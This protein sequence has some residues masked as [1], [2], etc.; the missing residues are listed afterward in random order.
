MQ[1]PGVE[2]PGVQVSGAQG[3]GVQGPR[4]AGFRCAGSRCAGCTC[5]MVF[6]FPGVQ[7]VSGSQ[8]GCVFFFSQPGRVSTGNSSLRKHSEH[9]EA[10]RPQDARAEVTIIHPA[11]KPLALG[12]GGDVFPMCSSFR[13]VAEQLPCPAPGKDVCVL[14][15]ELWHFSRSRPHLAAILISVAH[16]CSCEQ[17]KKVIFLYLK[18]RTHI[19]FP[20]D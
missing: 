1:V 9:R 10:T 6:R 5:A 20:V 18:Y 12:L 16:S 15:A 17:L 13:E 19:N 7:Y 8:V 4:C 11:G 14:V 2:V 3:P